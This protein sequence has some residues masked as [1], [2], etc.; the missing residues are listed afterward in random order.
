MN[1]DLLAGILG[2]LTGELPLSMPGKSNTSSAD[3][4]FTELLRNR[5]ADESAAGMSGESE[6]S[7]RSYSFAGINDFNPLMT[8]GLGSLGNRARNNQLRSADRGDAAGIKAVENRPSDQARTEKTDNGN[9]EDRRVEQKSEDKAETIQQNADEEATAEETTDET[10]RS[11]RELIAAEL[12]ADAEESSALQVEAEGDLG[13]MNRQE[14]LAAEIARLEEL[15]GAFSPEEKAALIQ[16]LQQLSPEDLKIMTESSDE[17]CQKLADLVNGMPDSAEK[18]E[19]L[20]MVESPEFLQMLQALADLQNSA[21]QATS[22]LPIDPAILQGSADTEQETETE[23]AANDEAT[24]P[25]MAQLTDVQEIVNGSAAASSG[26]QN[27][28]SADVDQEASEHKKATENTDEKNVETL[29]EAVSTEP[30]NSEES[31]R[32]EF[33]RL[34][35]PVD[36]ASSDNQLTETAE[37][38]TLTN[39]SGNQ[40]ASAQPATPEQVKAAVEEAAKKFFTLFTEKASAGDRTATAE[41]YSP[42]AIKRH[43]SMGNNSA[44]N[45]GNGFSSNTGTPASSMSAAR[46]ATPAPAAN[47]IFSQMLEKAEFLKTQNGSK[48]L[49]MELDPGELGKLE[50]ELTSRDGTVSAR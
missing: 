8:A 10:A 7:R 2:G 11:G 26:M 17:F 25:N 36:E 42:E 38:P 29:Q 48:V 35:Q 9:S 27:Q 5:L 31:L 47:Q 22:A 23:T 44:G 12:A 13:E 49:S 34:N 24:L 16:A 40:T 4:N 37:E 50:M 28:A 45:E 15:L 1:N 3:G 41:T 39:K 43:S 14:K 20:A 32:E 30:Q 6:V 33:K 19:L 21:T 46:P 18:D